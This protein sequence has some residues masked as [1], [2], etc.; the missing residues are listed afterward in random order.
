MASFFFFG[1]VGSLV[2]WFLGFGSNSATWWAILDLRLHDAAGGERVSNVARAG[3]L[4][5][6]A[7]RL[8]AAAIGISSPL[9]GPSRL[10]WQAAQDAGV[11]G[12]RSQTIVSEENGLAAAR[13]ARD[14]LILGAG[15]VQDLQA[16]LTHRVQAGQDSWTLPCKVVRVPASRAIQWLT[17]HHRARRRWRRRGGWGGWRAQDV[18]V[19]DYVIHLVVELVVAYLAVA[20]L[21]LG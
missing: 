3:R 12:E 13:G 16:L 20:S 4:A 18:L 5:V 8:V 19:H 6:L 9:Y 17:W 14:E 11:D 1:I 2:L 10:R 21:T 15:L 7:H